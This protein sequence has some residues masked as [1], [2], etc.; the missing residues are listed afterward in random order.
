MAQE[1]ENHKTGIFK[2]GRCN[3]IVAIEND[4]WHISISTPKASPSYEELKAARY[5][6]VP[7]GIYMAQI[8]PPSTEFVN[9]HPFCHHLFEIKSISRRIDDLQP[10]LKQKPAPVKSNKTWGF[11]SFIKNLVKFPK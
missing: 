11:I 9:I 2:M 8:F 1:T 7:D 10:I 6:F 5:K 3:V 4:A